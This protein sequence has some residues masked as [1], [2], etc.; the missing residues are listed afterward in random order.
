MFE[1]C[2]LCTKCSKM[3]PLDEF[4]KNKNF[5][6]GHSFQCKECTKLERIERKINN[7]WIYTF[8]ALKR[9]CEDINHDHYKNYGGRGIKCFL[10][11]EELK[12]LWFR[13]KAYEMKEP[14]IDRI[15]NDGNYE[16]SNCRY[17]EL[18]KNIAE[19]NTRILS[20][21][22]FQYTLDGTFLR[23]FSSLTEAAKATSQTHTNI[24]YCAN[25][26]TKTAGGFIWKYKEIK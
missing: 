10:T 11:E 26:K 6:D 18:S 19:R 24:G 15:D 13:D 2:K 3:K 14:S 16:F 25:G 4:Y 7:P 8:Y 17:K 20:K 21:P 1:V 5:K 22:I 23:E 12:T 9:R